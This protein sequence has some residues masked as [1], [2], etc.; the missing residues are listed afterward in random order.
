MRTL[1]ISLLV[2]ILTITISAQEG[3][4]WQN[5][6]PGNT[7]SINKIYF[8]DEDNGMVIGPGGLI[9]MTTNGGEAWKPVYTGVSETLIDLGFVNSNLGIIISDKS[10]LKTTD[11]G[12]NWEKIFEAEPNTAFQ[13]CSILDSLNFFVTV[14][15]QDGYQYYSSV[16]ISN[17]GGSSWSQTSELNG[18]PRE[19]YFINQ[20]VGLYFVAFR[21]YRTVDGGLSWTSTQFP[22]MYTVDISFC[23][24]LNGIL[25]SSS[26]TYVTDDGGLTWNQANSPPEYTSEALIYAPDLIIAAGSNQSIYKSTDLGNSWIQLLRLGGGTSVEFISISIANNSYF[27]S[28]YGT[29]YKSSDSGENWCS[30]K[31]GTTEYLHSINMVNRDFGIAVGGNG[32]I[33][34]THNGGA[35][36]QMQNSGT[37]EWLYSVNCI[38]TLNALAAGYS[39]VIIKTTDGGESWVPKNS[40]VSIS[41]YHLEMFDQNIGMA[42]GWGGTLLKTTDGG[43]SWQSQIISSMNFWISE[44]MD[45]SNIFIGGSIANGYGY[46]LRSQNA[47]VSW[48]TVYQALYKFP[49][50][51]CR[52]G[53]QSLIVTASDGWIIKSTDL[54]N[55]WTNLN[56]PR[57]YHGRI[58]FIDSINGLLSFDDGF[59]YRTT[60]GGSSWI[61][62]WPFGSQLRDIQMLNME[63]AVAVG[64]YGAI[65]STI[66]DHI[67]SVDY[68]DI[69]DVNTSSSNYLLLQNYPNP[70][71]PITKIQYSV[72]STQNI[73]LKVYDILG[74][75]IATLV[76]EE[77]PVGEYEVE[78]N[79]SALTSGIYFYQLKAGEFSETKK[80]IL[81]K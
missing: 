42:V 4:F 56:S 52:L 6:I 58:S 69:F 19:L 72:N 48:D 36:W 75:E 30:I 55:S 10:I 60:N 13:F 78:F 28:G 34:T 14:G 57:Q 41:V 74:R 47:G 65:I 71:N 79:G 44:Y 15:E 16:L 17:D 66:S 37:N 38:D 23:D 2:F 18:L 67:V 27:V 68:S 64:F 61:S 12:L 76:N 5:P 45:S 33:L 22:T 46:I 11:G 29:I 25:K 63:D 3:W 21:L 70:F 73:T 20:D 80:M 31:Q 62:E 7:Y 32:T 26:L 43:D 49:R 54:G 35:I 81:L 39:G 24:S 1:K 40:G 59:I 51:M 8:L 50:S 9:Y 77:K 53:D